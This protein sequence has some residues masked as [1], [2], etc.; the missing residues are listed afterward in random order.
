[1]YLREGCD[2]KSY[3]RRAGGRA[4]GRRPRSIDRPENRCCCRCRCPP[5]G[6]ASCDVPISFTGARI[7]Q[8]SDPPP[9]QQRIRRFAN[10][11][12]GRTAT[13]VTESRAVEEVKR[14]RLPSFTARNC[15]E[16]MTAVRN[17]ESRRENKAV[18]WQ[19]ESVWIWK[20]TGRL[21]T[22]HYCVPLPKKRRQVYMIDGLESAINC[23]LQQAKRSSGQIATAVTNRLTKEYSM[24]LW[25]GFC[26]NGK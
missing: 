11:R 20:S 23:H 24:F 16:L 22:K 2:D 14:K 8:N 1:M 13:R 7:S 17:I 18:H 4:G 21:Q 6:I 10:R 5:A 3:W 25:T 26:F 9:Q 15:Q 12:D 19:H